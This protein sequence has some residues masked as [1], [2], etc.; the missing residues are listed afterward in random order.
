VG[1]SLSPDQFVVGG[2]VDFGYLFKNANLFGVGEV[3]FGDDVTVWSFAGGLVYKAAGA[4]ESWT[5]YG[6][7]E[8]GLIIADATD[9]GSSTDLGVSAVGGIEKSIGN[10]SRFGVELRVGIVDTPDFK[11]AALWTFGP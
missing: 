1:F 7:G 8:I 2:Q 10:G 9:A 3:G 4:W 11:A 5:P 6:G